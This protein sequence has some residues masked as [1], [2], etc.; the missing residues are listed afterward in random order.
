MS[1]S[2]TAKPGDL[3]GRGGTI[4]FTIATDLPTTPRDNESPQGRP[5]Q[6]AE[7][8]TSKTSKKVRED[9]NAKKSKKPVGKTRQQN[10]GSLMPSK[11]CCVVV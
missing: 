11:P 7:G 2:S 10:G 5:S 8:Q 6:S 1:G 9:D 3:V 4:D